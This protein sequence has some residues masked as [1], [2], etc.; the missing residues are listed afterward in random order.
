MKQKL[1]FFSVALI[2]ST[3]AF[4]QFSIIDQNLDCTTGCSTLT[5]T[6]PNIENTIDYTV[7][8][9]SF[10]PPTTFDG[11]ENVLIGLDDRWSNAIGLPF[12]FYFYGNA[13]S[14]LLTSGNG[15]IS[16]DTSLADGYHQWGF[17]EELPNNTNAAFIGANIFGAMHDMDI[18][19]HGWEII[20]E[21]PFRAFVYS[22]SLAPNYLCDDLFTTQMMVLYETTNVIEVYLLNKPLCE[23]WNNG[24]SVV[25]I[26]NPEG[27][28]AVVPVGRNTGQWEAINEAW[29]FYPSGSTTDNTYE[30]Y[31]QTNTLIGSDMSINVCPTTVETY[32][33]VVTYT[34]P[35]TGTPTTISESI[36][37]SP[38]LVGGDPSNLEICS[39]TEF[40]LFDLT[41]Q[42]NIIN[43]GTTC[44]IINYY[45][46][47]DDA[48]N[49]TNVISN[50]SSYTNTSNPQTIYVRVD[51][52]NTSNYETTQFDLIVSLSPTIFASEIL[53]CSFEQGFAEFDLASMD[54]SV[55]GG[56]PDYQ[57]RYYRTFADADNENNE[58]LSP[59]V[60]EEIFVQTIIARVDDQNSDCYSLI[61]CYLN[62]ID[63]VQLQTVTLFQCDDESNDGIAEFNL[64]DT[65][66]E[67]T[68]GQTDITVTFFETEVDAQNNNNPIASPEVYTNNSNPQ[69]IFTRGESTVEE[70]IGFGIVELFVEESPNIIMPSPYTICDFD[71][72]NDGFS[73]FNLSTKDA[74]ILEGLNANNYVVSYYET[75]ADADSGL[76]ALNSSGYLNVVANLQ[77]IYVRVEN[78]FA[79]CFDTTS[80]DLIVDTDCPIACEENVTFCY[81]NDET[82][83]YSFTSDNG[84]PLTVF[85]N[86]GQVEVDWDELIVLDSD[87]VTNL[88]E[89]TPYGNSGDVTGLTFTS[90]GDTITIKV[91]SDGSISCQTNN[92][93]PIDFNIFCIDAIGLIEVNAFIDQNSNGVLDASELNFSEG[94]FTYE[95]NNDGVINY[96]NSSTGSFLIPITEEGDTYD[97]S[98]VMF[99][100]YNSCLSQPFTLVEDVTAV[101]GETVE[102][103]FPVNPITDCSDIGVYLLSYVPPRPGI[104]D[105]NNLIIEN[106]G[107]IP[108]SGSVEFTHD[109]L[110]SLLDV[111]YVEPGNTVTNTA[112][113]FILNFNNLQPNNEEV[114]T[115]RLNVP[116]S[117]VAGDIITNSV[118][119]NVSDINLENNESILT[120]VVVNSY[121]PNNKVESHGPEIKLNDFTSEDYLFYIINFQNLGTAE[122]I[123]IRVEDVLDSQLDVTTF[124]MLN[125]SHDYV[126]TR[127]D[128][129]LTWEFEDINL[130]SESMDEPNSHG[131]IY[132]KIKPLVGYA[133]GDIIPNYADIYF[134]FNPAVTTNTFETEFVANLSVEG[135]NSTQFSM[136]PN[137]ATQLVNV[138]FNT[139][140]NSNIKVNIFN[141]QGKSVMKTNTVSNLNSIQFN[142][143]NLSKGMYFVELVG[144]NFKI[145]EKLIVE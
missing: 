117:L 21:A 102:V 15:A 48:E 64:A 49:D 2:F 139:N 145:V 33:V 83:E 90:S 96:V 126:L 124:K 95:V 122:A 119:Y 54:V 80:L 78:Q 91:E 39:D 98:F 130:P 25:G 112:T 7:E 137:P 20:G 140:V 143:S 114:V 66:P 99:E 71:G 97:I 13:Y 70:C 53:A 23:T 40:S 8:S 16:F 38:S 75:Q 19:Q 92:Y 77:T 110:L 79:G 84:A 133:E 105:Y 41:V 27:T 125:A 52:I 94:V 89:D 63:S 116:P 123:N 56:N 34:D 118:V 134:D 4:S 59:Y 68:N 61:E 5:A 36:T 121:D 74:E 18:H 142:V 141:L 132:F 3:S 101:I 128:G 113:G 46:S 120:E 69:A 45:E 115:V 50:P 1:L 136:Y 104:I 65:I 67:I 57:V 73:T 42:T 106:L 60:N 12:N 81:V 131:Y 26:Q 138:Q 85:F 43:G 93:T 28:Q 109:P 11:L 88:N 62:V 37:L 44:S 10:N 58:L 22:T 24:S 14:A 103:N 6:F 32:T 107:S 9:I 111:L 86:S 47:L 108:V 76:N 87:G 30:W 100:G 31:D 135:F 127:V 82:T 55:T 144:S 51:D 29:R 35:S 72:T 17:A 129:N